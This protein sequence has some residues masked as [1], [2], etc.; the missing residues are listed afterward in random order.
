MVNDPRDEL[1][2]VAFETHYDAYYEELL[3]D[4][5]INR[6]QWVDEVSRVL[7]ALTASTSALSGWA[8]WTEPHF[9][10]VWGITAGV[11]AVLSIVHT[12]LGVP[13]RLKDHG[14][15]KRQFAS[16]RIDVETFRYRMRLDTNFPVVDFTKEFVEYR[17]R[18]SDG[19]QL[20]K[21]DILRTHCLQ[22][23]VQDQLNQRLAQEISQS[24]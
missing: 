18:Y 8:L 12:S 6:W 7:V 14:D 19:F 1:W 9:K 2:E 5:L 15:V 16:V 24:A 11:A 13:G 4:S 22:K 17:R 10:A 21:N 20:L 23:K 3:E